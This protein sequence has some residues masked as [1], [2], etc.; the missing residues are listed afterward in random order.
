MS[1]ILSRLPLAPRKENSLANPPL[2]RPG[3]EQNLP[4]FVVILW[5]LQS[6]L[7]SGP[8]L[9]AQD[10]EAGIEQLK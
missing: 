9:E 2:E 6:L 8:E 5:P 4:V 3:R 1:V 7:R 10:K